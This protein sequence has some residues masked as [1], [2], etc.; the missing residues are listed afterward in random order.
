MTNRTIHIL[1]PAIAAGLAL[2]TLVALAL[3]AATGIDLI[4]WGL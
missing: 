2:A 1:Q 3:A 4:G